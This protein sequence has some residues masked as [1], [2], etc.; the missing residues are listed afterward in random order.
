MDILL[1]GIAIPDIENLEL[2]TLGLYLNRIRQSIA[3]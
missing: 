1:R 3:R 2:G